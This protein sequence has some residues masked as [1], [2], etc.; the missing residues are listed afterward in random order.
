MKKKEEKVIL[1]KKPKIGEMYAF[2][3]AGDKLKG[4][5]VSE[6]KKMTE[7]YK[8]KWFDLVVKKGQFAH[9]RDFKYPVSIFDIIEKVEKK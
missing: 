4:T 7:L 9:D 8:H 2:T 1:V 6:N 3:F 5:L